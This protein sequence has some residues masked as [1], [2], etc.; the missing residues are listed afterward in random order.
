[1]EPETSKF[2]S[3]EMLATYLASTPLLD[4]SWRMC[5]HANTAAP[6]SFAV[7]RVGKVAYLA[8]SGVQMVDCSEENCRTLVELG[9]GAN[10]IFDGFCDRGGGDQ[11]PIMVHGGLLQAFLCF[12][13][14]KN[15]QNKMHEIMNECKSVVVTG[16][17]LGGALASLTALCLLSSIKATSASVHVLCITY[18]SPMLGNKA[19]SQAIQQ[20]RWAGNFC[21]VAGQYDIVPRMLFAPATPIMQELSILFA[22]WQSCMSCTATPSVV[23]Q[24][25]YASIAAVFDTVL[26]CAERR[27]MEDGETGRGLFWPFGSY[28]L[29]TAEGAICL[30]NREAIVKLLYLMLAKGSVDSYVADHLKYEYYVSRVCWHFLQR[31]SLTDVCSSESSN[32]AGIALA[33]RSSGIGFQEAVYGTAKNCLAMAR[34]SGC[35]RTIQNAKMAVSLRKF[36]HIR[37]QIE[38]YKAFCDGSDDQLGYYDSFKL[39]ST[40]MK[41]NRVN[42]YR[43]RI[44]IFWDKLIDMMETNQL[45]H[46]F[47]ELAKYVN[48]SHSYTLLVEPLEIAEYYKTC[49]HKKKGH[50]IEHGRERRFKI[51]D[52]WW[53]DRKVGDE[54]GNPRSRFA[55]L[56]Q[57]SCFWARV[58]EARDCV[59]LIT[60]E[61]DSGKQAFL[62]SKI[63]K[64]E[65]YAIRMIERKEVSVD[66]LAKYSSYNLFRDEWN[67]LK[68]RMQVVLPSRLPVSQDRMVQKFS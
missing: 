41:G 7:D 27:A 1:M 2:E 58:E 23:S 67:E 52:K 54:E 11:E 4:E 57:D 59:H 31:R 53:R 9:S 66:V 63:E 35:R 13:H 42:I 34:Q 24:L 64:F 39:R 32:D 15:F 45:T 17:S 40:S 30:D 6:L 3:S 65:Q 61:M 20:E 68:S 48:A 12:F 25:S 46:D 44:G 26:P 29:C 38:W 8:F 10:G 5:S 47:H 33:L 55:S 51:F 16:H 49:M 22:F 43:I 60:G 36:A 50:Y 19:F 14:T 56:T 18:G 28:M 21:H 62:S 37:V